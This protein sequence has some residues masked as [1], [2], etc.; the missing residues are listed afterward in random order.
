METYEK[1]MKAERGDQVV[2][3]TGESLAAS[4]EPP[5]SSR[6]ALSARLEAQVASNNGLCNLVQKRLTTGVGSQFAYIAVR[7]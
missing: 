7:L 1:I 2:Y 3:W 6:A 4:C 5:I